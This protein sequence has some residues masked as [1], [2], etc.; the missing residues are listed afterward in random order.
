VNTSRRLCASVFWLL[1]FLFC[2]SSAFCC[3][4]SAA[5]GQLASS[6]SLACLLARSLAF[7]LAFSFA[8]SFV[9]LATEIH[10]VENEFCRSRD[11]V[12]GET[13]YPDTDRIGRSVHKT[14]PV[15]VDWIEINWIQINCYRPCI[16][17]PVSGARGTTR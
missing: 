14:P 11:S 1:R 2:C 12:N 10:K 16:Q 17:H 3:F 4:L 5:V 7:L 9:R 15:A 8:C 13:D 6:S